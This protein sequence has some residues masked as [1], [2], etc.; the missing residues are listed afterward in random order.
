MP[1]DRY[2]V[3]DF[4]PRNEIFFANASGGQCSLIFREVIQTPVEGFFFN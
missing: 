2:G 4:F 1:E 3:K